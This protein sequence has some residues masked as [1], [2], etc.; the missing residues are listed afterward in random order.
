MNNIGLIVGKDKTDNENI[1]EVAYGP[2]TG[3]TSWSNKGNNRCS[4]VCVYT[5]IGGDL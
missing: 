3:N 2:L 5:R 4:I 1:L